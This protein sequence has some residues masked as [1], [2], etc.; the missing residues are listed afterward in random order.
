MPRLLTSLELFLRYLA[1]FAGLGALAISISRAVIAQSHPSGQQ[2]GAAHQILRTPHLIISS[3]LF[4]ILAYLIWL[5]LPVHMAVALQVTLTLLGA[6]ILFAS[7]GLYLW[8]LITLGENFNFA[9]GFGV[10]LQKTHRL[11]KN[12]PYAHIRHPMYLGVILACWG[13]LLLYRTWTMLV[14]AILM[15]GLVNRARTE[16]AALKQAFGVEWDAYRQTVP[17]WLPRISIPR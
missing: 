16:D 12:G 11:V 17:A 4:F 7:I 1:G 9:S 5:P 3:I 15:F 13:G 14:F 10:R 6:L 8:G 2:T